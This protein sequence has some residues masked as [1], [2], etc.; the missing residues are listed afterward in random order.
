MHSFDH[1]QKY[2]NTAVTHKVEGWVFM[3]GGGGGSYRTKSLFQLLSS[4]KRKYT[5]NV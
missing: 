4:S 3:P 5:R 2:Y 1:H